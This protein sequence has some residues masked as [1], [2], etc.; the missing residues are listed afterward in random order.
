MEDELDRLCTRET[1]ESVVERAETHVQAHMLR[2]RDDL[3]PKPSFKLGFEVL[4]EL[5]FCG[6]VLLRP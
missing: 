4:L 6:L 5:F 3:V 2:A 1:V